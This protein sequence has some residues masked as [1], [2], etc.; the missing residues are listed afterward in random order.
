M[1]YGFGADQSGPKGRARI[2][3]GLLFSAVFLAEVV[4]SGLEGF[5]SHAQIT[6]IVVGNSVEIVASPVHGQIAASVT[7]ITFV[8]H[9]L[10]G[11]EVLDAVRSAAEGNVEGG[12]GEVSILPEGFGQQYSS[13]ET[14]RQE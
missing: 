13:S 8:G 14:P 10:T 7:G 9:A 12:F 2:A 1:R 6:V 11:P 4:G 3:R 5:Q